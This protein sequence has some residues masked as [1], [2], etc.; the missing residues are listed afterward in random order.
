MGREQASPSSWEALWREVPEF[1]G[2][3]ALG[4]EHKP[5]LTHLFRTYPPLISEFTFTNLFIWRQAYRIQLSRYRGFLCLLA[6]KGGSSFFFPPIGEGDLV[7]CCRMLLRTMAGQGRVAQIA[8]VPEKTLSLFDW[9]AEGFALE[10]DRDNSDYVYSVEDLVYLRGRK[11]HRKRNHIKRFK[12]QY[13]HQYVPLTPDL[14]SQ[15]LDLQAS[16][17]DLKHCEADP[18][19]SQEFL[20]IKE[21]LAHFEALEIQGGAILIDGKVEA[22]TLG[23]PLNPDTVVIHIEKANPAFDGLYPALNQAF[24]EH[25]WTSFTYV[26]REQDLGEEGL[27]R[28][29]ESYFPHH[30]V[31]KYS[32]SLKG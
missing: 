11:Y 12:E 13:P 30:M 21:A 27:R 10:Y 20:A 3:Q 15:C 5:L 19:L 18:G 22:F 1:P 25:Q 28:A 7:D 6:E 24:L 26:N 8:R 17:C 4:F 32:L 14:I 9:E 23:E 16:W 2:T 31:H 29:K